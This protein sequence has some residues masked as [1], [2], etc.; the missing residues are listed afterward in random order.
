MGA[1]FI[2]SKLPADKFIIADKGCDS[3]GYR[4]ALQV[5]GITSCIPHGKGRRVMNKYSKT[6]Y[7]QRDKVETCS[8]FFEYWRRIATRYDRCVD[9]FMAAITIAASIISWI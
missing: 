9:I 6:S 5:K 4:A 1:K 8:A 3:V 7:K 2:Y